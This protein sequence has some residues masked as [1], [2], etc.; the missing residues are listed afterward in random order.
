[1]KSILTH[2]GKLNINPE[3]KE[4]KQKENKHKERVREREHDRV[5]ICDRIES[6]A[7]NCKK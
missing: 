6:W 2:I 1:M 3:R 5:V 4:K 7:K